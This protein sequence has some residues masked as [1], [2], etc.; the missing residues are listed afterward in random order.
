MMLKET[1]RSVQEFTS[2]ISKDFLNF[3][4]EYEI[5]NLFRNRRF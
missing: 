1:K 5:I 3:E 2:G 4:K